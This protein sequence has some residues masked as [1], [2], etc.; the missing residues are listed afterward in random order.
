VA[1]LLEHVTQAAFVYRHQWQAGDY[2]MWDNRS[3]LHRGRRY[4]LQDRRDLRRTTT[5]E[6]H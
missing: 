4:D 6:R 5:I 2:V 3:T 1:E